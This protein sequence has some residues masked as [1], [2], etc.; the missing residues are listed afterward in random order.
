MTKSTS[1]KTISEVLENYGYV[2]S[3]DITVKQLRTAKDRTLAQIERIMEDVIGADDMAKLIRPISP[4][5]KDEDEHKQYQTAHTKDMLR[6][7]QR[8]RLKE[9]L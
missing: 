8:Q 3:G 5:Q 7:T 2:A 6:A 4:F 1:P 9:R